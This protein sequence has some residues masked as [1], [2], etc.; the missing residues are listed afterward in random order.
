MLSPHSVAVFGR[1]PGLLATG[2]HNSLQD[3]NSA[4]V[5]HLVEIVEWR[6][7]DP[8]VTATITARQASNRKTPICGIFNRLGG[9]LEQ[10]FPYTRGPKYRY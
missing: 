9:G 2:R 5:V 3:S 4:L 8:C 1:V 10:D 6:R 7:F